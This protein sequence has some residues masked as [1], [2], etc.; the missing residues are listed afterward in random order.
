MWYLYLDES[1]D[2]GFDFV[3]KSPSKFFTVSILVI[4][5]ESDNRK[6]Q[7]VAK[8]TLRRK[9]QKKNN[10]YELKGSKCPLHVKKYFYKKSKDIK[11]KIYSITLDKR[12]AYNRLEK[13]KERVYN[14]ISRLVLNQIPL[15][16][17]NK[18][19]N[20]IVDKSKTKKNIA[21]FDHYILSQIKSV[22]DPKTPLNIYHYN[23]TTSF[24]LQAVDLF[25]WGIRRKYEHKDKEWLNVF[26]N[27]VVYDEVYK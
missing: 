6:L 22:F 10:V 7:K 21:E 3:N 12:K 18:G 23:S 20:I 16:N 1:G 9:F 24:G 14:F 25:C 13:D 17:S 15:K 19:V 2:L 26:K 8:I 4:K 27:K 5:N 11:F